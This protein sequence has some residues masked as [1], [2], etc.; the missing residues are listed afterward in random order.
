M[1]GFV[2]VKFSH[3][4][5]NFVQS[6]EFVI[7]SGELNWSLIFCA[8]IQTIF[9][10]YSASPLKVTKAKLPTV[11]VWREP[12]RKRDYSQTHSI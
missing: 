6:I 12:A 2:I 8:C 10:L 5:L 3:A 7:F 9:S 1:V 4:L 11:W